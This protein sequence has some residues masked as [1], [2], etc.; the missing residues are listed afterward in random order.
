MDKK[1]A[2]LATSEITVDERGAEH[3]PSYGL[4]RLGHVSSSSRTPM[5]GSRA[6]HTRR[7]CLEISRGRVY[8]G[9][10]EEHAFDEHWIEDSDI[11][12][13]YLT[14]SQFAEL[15]SNMNQ[16]SAI[17]CTLSYVMDERMSQP[18]RP[19]SFAGRFKKRVM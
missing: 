10:N 11:V 13:C 3:H 4:V 19:E 1:K 17:P 15:I 14:Y 7:I 16:G 2:D 12:R 6:Y 5:V 8:R 18:P 9:Q